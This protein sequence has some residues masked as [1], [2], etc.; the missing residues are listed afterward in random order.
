LAPFLLWKK[1]NIGDYFKTF[2]KKNYSESTP[3]VGPPNF[4]LPQ[5]KK[6]YK[7]IKLALE[8]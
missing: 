7:K 8:Y 1:T 6:A 3:E 5:L 4:F 2:V